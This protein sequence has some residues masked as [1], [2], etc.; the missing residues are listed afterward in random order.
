VQGFHSW[1]DGA[2]KR[3]PKRLDRRSAERCISALRSK[4]RT[5]ASGSR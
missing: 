2:L 4:L 5:L 1:L 3:L